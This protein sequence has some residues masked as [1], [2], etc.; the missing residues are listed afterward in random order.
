[1][2]SA[3]EWLEF[4]L[5][6]VETPTSNF[7]EVLVQLRILS[8]R[9]GNVSIKGI[10]KTDFA[11]IFNENLMCLCVHRLKHQHGKRQQTD[12]QVENIFARIKNLLNCK[13]WKIDDEK[14]KKL[15]QSLW[16][17]KVLTEN[18]RSSRKVKKINKLIQKW[19]KVWKSSKDLE[20]RRAIRISWL[21]IPKRYFRSSDDEKKY[22][23]ITSGLKYLVIRILLPKT[24]TKLKAT[25][26]S[27]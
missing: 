6:K 16:K 13:M 2:K 3:G 23:I 11:W 19:L 1:M 10:F 21:N 7:C 15:S 8:A 12:V 18:C 14:L 9:F 26:R 17:C 4:F 22:Q 27:Y 5:Q 24:V 25:F 20:R